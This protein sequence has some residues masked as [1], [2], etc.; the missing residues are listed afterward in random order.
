MQAQMP[1]PVP[2]PTPVPIWDPPPGDAPGNP[3]DDVPPLDDPP[4]SDPIP[5]PPPMQM[6][7]VKAATLH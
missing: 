3:G 6:C 7:G 1:E 2:T 5:T 4:G